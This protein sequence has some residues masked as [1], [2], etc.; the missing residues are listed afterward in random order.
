MIPEQLPFSRKT[1]GPVR[2]IVGLALALALALAAGTLTGCSFI[3]HAAHS[4]GSQGTSTSQHIQGP[5][6]HQQHHTDYVFRSS[7]LL[8]EHFNK[9]GREMG[10]A[11]PEDYEEAA[12][13]VANDPKALHKTQAADGDHV[14][15]LER[16]NELVI[17][18]TDGY[19]RTYFCPDSGKRYFDRQ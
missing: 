6:D 12:S 14:Y 15:Y 7:R 4:G 11:T 16:A 5:S 9:H 8:K 19:L 17:V 18:S 3:D 2:R 1:A 10:F 13:S